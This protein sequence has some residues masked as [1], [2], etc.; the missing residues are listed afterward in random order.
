MNNIKILYKISE[1]IQELQKLKL[2]QKLFKQRLI[3]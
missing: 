3:H 2:I 1:D